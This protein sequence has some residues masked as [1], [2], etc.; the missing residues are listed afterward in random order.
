MIDNIL[1][2]TK[3]AFSSDKWK[4]WGY[5]LFS[6]ESLR[7]NRAAR[8]DNQTCMAHKF[9]KKRFFSKILKKLIEKLI[10]RSTTLQIS[11]PPREKIV[12]PL[13][14]MITT[15]HS[16]FTFR[17]QKSCSAVDSTPHGSREL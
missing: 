7:S 9:L 3:S 14:S 13:L 16:R 12:P 4:K 6:L 2:K 11:P 10:P 5:S 17:V 8:I 1:T 15:P